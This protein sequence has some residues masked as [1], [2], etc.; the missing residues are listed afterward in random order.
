[1]ITTFPGVWS[2]VNHSAH[3]TGITWPCTGDHVTLHRATNHVNHVTLES[4]AACKINLSSPLPRETLQYITPYRMETTYW[5][6][7]VLHYFMW[8]YRKVFCP[9]LEKT[10]LL[11]N[12]VGCLQLINAHWK[13]EL[14]PNLVER[15]QLINAHRK[16]ELLPNL[17]GYVM[18]INAHWK[19][20]NFCPILQGV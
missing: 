11:P 15:L 6:L 4:S 20:L 8:H 16:T 13:T 7:Q 19:R 14:L 5:W 1:M 2:S 12:L 3:I 10:E 9:K 17:A 18:L